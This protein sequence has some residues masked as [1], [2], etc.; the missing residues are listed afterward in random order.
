MHGK[1]A[2]EIQEGEVGRIQAELDRQQQRQRQIDSQ[3]RRLKLGE[4]ASAWGHAP[5]RPKAAQNLHACFGFPTRVGLGVPKGM[6]GPTFPSWTN[7]PACMGLVSHVI[8][9]S[10]AIHRGILPWSRLAQPGVFYFILFYVILFLFILLYFILLWLSSL[11]LQHVHRRMPS[12]VRNF[13]S[14]L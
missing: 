10:R 7:R 9:P 1:L 13:H 6:L 11:H 2:Q 4:K 3:N 14:S 5:V 8:V 12:L